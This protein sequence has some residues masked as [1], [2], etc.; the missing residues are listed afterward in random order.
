MLPRCRPRYVR[1]HVL[2]IPDCEVEFRCALGPRRGELRF[3][4][5]GGVHTRFQVRNPAPYFAGENGVGRLFGIVLHAGCLT[6]QVGCGGGDNGKGVHVLRR[7]VGHS[8]YFVL[9]EQNGT[10]RA[11]GQALRQFEDS[12]RNDPP[13]SV[14]AQSSQ[15][16][17]LFRALAPPTTDNPPSPHTRQ[18]DGCGHCGGDH[19]FV[20]RGHKSPEKDEVSRIKYQG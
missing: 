11:V 2:G 18:C 15:A 9:I 4:F 3:A 1:H 19:Q 14:H 10:D 6:G 12:S 5:G 16:L 13:A 20:R 8:R 17:D 7:F